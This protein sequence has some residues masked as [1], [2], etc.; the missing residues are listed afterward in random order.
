[1]HGEIAQVRT[2]RPRKEQFMEDRVEIQR[3]VKGEDD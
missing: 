3:M 1:M 2:V